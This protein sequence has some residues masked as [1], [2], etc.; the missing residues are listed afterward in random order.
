MQLYQ[1][2][3]TFQ[4]E[5]QL[6][7]QV[8]A[9]IQQ[10]ISSEQKLTQSAVATMLGV[11]L[12]ELKSYTRVKALLEAR[13]GTSE[14]D[15]QIITAAQ[16]RE[17]ELVGQVEC[18]IRQLALHGQKVTY[19]AITKIV[20]KNISTLKG[21]PRVKAM[22]EQKAGWYQEWVR[23]LPEENELTERVRDAIEALI[24]HRQRVTYKTVGRMVGFPPTILKEYPRVVALLKQISE[25]VM[26]QRHAELL[27]KVRVAIQELE[28][29][30]QQV[31][32]AAIGRKI[33]M[34]PSNLYQ[35]PEV[36]SLVQLVVKERKAQDYARRFH[37]REEELML[38][39]TEAIRNLQVAGSPIT[40]KAIANS[41]G[42]THTALNHYP[43]VKLI[44]D[45]FIKKPKRA[46]N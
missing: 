23:T 9:A 37:L 8:Q 14:Y 2:K 19:K 10:M 44:I 16:Q 41:V 17:G 12:L 40:A 26:H 3:K 33:C 24:S 30:G 7:I 28:E 34:R 43:K 36:I 21:Y 35:Y 42:V 45:E 6:L 39:V 32:K 31:T 18:A 27:A 25:K 1:T 20:G 15:C 13:I 38:R 46:G 29:S 5:E 22:L 11:G 4:R